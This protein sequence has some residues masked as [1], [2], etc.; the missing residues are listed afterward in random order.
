MHSIADHFVWN[1]H[2]ARHPLFVDATN[3]SELLAR[4]IA[5]GWKYINLKSEKPE[6]DTRELSE[7]VLCE[8]LAGAVCDVGCQSWPT[9]ILRGL[10]IATRR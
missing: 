10:K 1:L 4:Q 2:F 9:C 7:Q 3:S 8:W 5:N 6:S